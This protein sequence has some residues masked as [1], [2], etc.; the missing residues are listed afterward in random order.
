ML[1]RIGQF[2]ALHLALVKVANLV[3]FPE[4]M[5]QTLARNLELE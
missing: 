2:L 3:Q 1:T 4:Q 5:G